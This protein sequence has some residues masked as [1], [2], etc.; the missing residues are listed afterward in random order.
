MLID[1][2]LCFFLQVMFVL[3][4]LGVGVI[5]GEPTM[6]RRRQFGPYGH[7]TYN[8]NN[9]NNYNYNNQNN[10]NHNLNDYSPSQNH[11]RRNQNLQPNHHNHN[12]QNPDTSDPDC[13][14]NHNN[15]LTQQEKNI[16][17]NNIR[18]ILSKR[19]LESSLWDRFFGQD[20]S[21]DLESDLTTLHELSQRFG[22]YDILP[23]D[24]KVTRE[25][26]YRYV[27]CMLVRGCSWK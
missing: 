18:R 11:V 10:N 9:N 22:V 6:G 24:L 26:L 15:H 19:K 12:Y 7:P 1:L 25:D 16:I 21:D 13:N 3:L 2:L 23:D 5:M 27:T 20:E 14:H 4:A 8:N 17:S